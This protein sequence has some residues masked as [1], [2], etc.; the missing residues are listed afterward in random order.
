MQGDSAPYQIYY[1]MPMKKHWFVA[2]SLFTVFFVGCS[3]TSVPTNSTTTPNPTSATTD[4]TSGKMGDTL[5]YL[6]VVYTVAKVER[7]PDEVPASYYNYPTI[8]TPK[9][10]DA[11]SDY[12]RVEF[13]VRNNTPAT[14]SALGADFQLIT[15]DIVSVQPAP[16]DLVNYT[17]D[18]QSLI[19]D[20][21]I[22]P[23]VTKT[24]VLYFIVP[25]DSES[26]NFHIPDLTSP[27]LAKQTIN[28]ELQD[29]TIVDTQEPSSDDDNSAT[30][31]VNSDQ[32]AGAA[33]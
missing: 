4:T 19:V 16:S 5:Q 23:A 18:G 13:T 32:P 12:V 24:F 26:L 7:F 22:D 8:A 30:V 14:I 27:V 31:P 20:S 9:V 29:T 15:A 28:F 3:N 6:D 25:E 21:E 11:G 17:P 2:L 33:E 10:A 1:T